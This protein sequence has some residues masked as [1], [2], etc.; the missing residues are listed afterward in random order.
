MNKKDLIL[1]FTFIL[2]LSVLSAQTIDEFNHGAKISYATYRSISDISNYSITAQ[3]GDYVMKNIA[4]PLVLSEVSIFTGDRMYIFNP[5][6]ILKNIGGRI[7]KLDTEVSVYPPVYDSIDFDHTTPMTSKLPDFTIYSDTEWNYSAKG[8]LT[9]FEKIQLGFKYERIDFFSYIRNEDPVI[10]DSD[11]DLYYSDP[12]EMALRENNIYQEYYLNLLDI[13]FGKIINRR[14]GFNVKG[15]LDRL[16]LFN[17]IRTEGTQLDSINTFYV[18]GLEKLPFLNLNY[19][20][21]FDVWTFDFHFRLRSDAGNLWIKPS[22]MSQG[23]Y[24]RSVEILY[25]MYPV[26]SLL[27]GFPPGFWNEASDMVF[28]Q[29]FDNNMSSQKESGMFVTIGPGMKYTR[30]SPY[31]IQENVRYEDEYSVFSPCLH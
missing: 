3:L 30:E 11:T 20:N 13:D 17:T 4:N 15:K 27:L 5:K 19:M 29:L 12:Y 28:T 1:L 9:L 8:M 31:F 23:N 26:F 18:T 25:D 21:A 7:L 22:F 16:Q 2:S 6:L 14:T 24:W 10:H